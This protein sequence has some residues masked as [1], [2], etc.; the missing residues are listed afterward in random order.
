MGLNFKSLKSTETASKIKPEKKNTH[1][2]ENSSFFFPTKVIKA[3][4]PDINGGSQKKKKR[5]HHIQAR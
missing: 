2:N 4:K 3:L 5:T 1:T